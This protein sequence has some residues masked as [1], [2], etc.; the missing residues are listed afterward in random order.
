MQ[1][2]DE[3]TIEVVAGQGGNGIVSFRRESHVPYGGPDGGDGGRGGDVVIAADPRATTLLDHRYRR[4]YRADKGVNGGPKNMTGR[5]GDD[6]VV[7]V[8]L[9]TM[10]YDGA[11]GALIADVVEPEQRV[12]VAKGGRG[13]H[14]NARF[15]T[16]TRR[17]PRFAHDGLPGEERTLKLS[18]KVMADVGLVGLPNAGKSTLIRAITSSQAKVGA[19]PFTTLVPNLGVYRRGERDVVIADVPGLIEGAHAGQG[20][21]DQ[22]LKHLERTRALVHMVSLSPDSPDPLEAWQVVNRELSEWSE[23]LMALPQLVLLNKIDLV[24]DRYELTLW[25]EAFEELGVQIHPISALTGEHVDE[26]MAQ[27]IGHLD[28]ASADADEAAPWSP[29]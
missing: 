7:Y 15:V 13:G 8:P 28:A 3:A 1:F 26:V 19:Y 25:R 24:D 20:L 12:V 22:F 5:G 2:V 11:T 16:P 9:G 4:W 27:V 14:G 17:A 21:G 10:I 6:A 29:I 18:L 23:R